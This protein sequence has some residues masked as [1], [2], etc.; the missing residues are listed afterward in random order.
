MTASGKHFPKLS[1]AALERAQ[2]IFADA[3][4]SHAEQPVK[5]PSKGPPQTPLRTSR[6]VFKTPTRMAPKSNVQDSVD[7]AAESMGAYTHDKAASQAPSQSPT[8]PATTPSMSSAG[9]STAKGRLLP[10][11]SREA[12]RQAEALL[13][14]GSPAET[15][16]KPM[17]ST[18]TARKVAPSAAASATRPPVPSLAPAGSPLRLGG[19][20]SDPLKALPTTPK[21]PVSR[22]IGSQNKPFKSPLTARSRNLAN[23]PTSRSYESPRRSERQEI[24]QIFDVSNSAPRQSWKECFTEVKLDNI[25]GRQA[26]PDDILRMNSVLSK[27]HKFVSCSGESL[28]AEAITQELIK[29]GCQASLLTTDWVM[30]HYRSIVWKLACMVRQSPRLQQSYWNIEMVVSQLLYRYQRE[31]NMAHRSALKLAVERD[32]PASAHMVLCVS[33]ASPE[34]TPGRHLGL[35]EIELTDGWYFIMAKLDQCLAKALRDKKIFTGLKLH[36][37]NAKLI[38]AGTDI[39]NTDGAVS[40][41]LNANSVR[42]AAWDAKLG[43]QRQRLFVSGLASLSADGGSAGCVDVV[44]CRV[45]PILYLDKSIGGRNI[46]RNQKE[47]DIEQ[48]R[49]EMQQSKAADG[50]FRRFGGGYE[51][52][53]PLHSAQDGATAPAQTMDIRER[54]RRFDALLGFS[55][56]PDHGERNVTSFVNIRI[57]DYPPEGTSPDE[58]AETMLTIWTPSLDQLAEITEGTRLQIYNIQ[59]ISPNRVICKNTSVVLKA[60]RQISCR[61]RPTTPERL[62]RSTYLPRS[63]FW[64]SELAV[65]SHGDEVDMVL[66]VERKLKL[67]FWMPSRWLSL[68]DH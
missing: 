34:L 68:C 66:V 43:L 29:R 2:R 4:D 39:L 38:G 64:S 67:S 47:E 56:G 9:F 25:D 30:N 19:Y 59:C 53:P 16:R 26:L 18:P 63:L 51:N 60:S 20:H 48:R 52:E 27:T 50:S 37:Q 15:D 45:Y 36:V 35:D 8:R 49:W 10:P 21:T 41:Q 44:V 13:S 42:R 3:D 28:D 5:L 12:L 46:I 55:E 24:P 31:V 62:A 32:H 40:L 14:S 7:P 22:A 11:P 6:P 33:R 58:V 54:R 65:K 61:I 17:P 23:P 57:C 1:G